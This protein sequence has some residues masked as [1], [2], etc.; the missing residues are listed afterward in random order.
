MKGFLKIIILRNIISAV[1]GKDIP[2]KLKCMQ[3]ETEIMSDKNPK[4][5]CV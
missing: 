2:L 3:L 5:Q 1:F 4:L